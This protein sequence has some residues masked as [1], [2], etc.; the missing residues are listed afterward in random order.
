[1]KARIVHRRLIYRLVIPALVALILLPLMITPAGAAGSQT[2]VGRWHRLNPGTPSEHETLSCG[3]DQVL[4]CR[5]SIQPEPLLNYVQPPYSIYGIFT[6]QEHSSWAP[7]QWFTE[8]FPEV[9]SVF[10]GEMEY[11]VNDT[12]PDLFVFAD[13]IVTESDGQEVLYL[14]WIDSPYGSFACPWYR[15]FEA[16]LSA[17]PDCITP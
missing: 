7:P 1:M 6:G 12:S 11:Y 17:N 10:G 4:T 5:Y 9:I 16:A 8:E 13:L 14:Y 3:G 2:L 15:S